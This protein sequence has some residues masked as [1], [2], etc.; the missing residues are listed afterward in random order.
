MLASA[1]KKAAEKLAKMVNPYAIK[2]KLDPV[3]I[4]PGVVTTSLAAYLQSPH[5]SAPRAA[6]QERLAADE[7]SVL[8]LARMLEELYHGKRLPRSPNLA[9]ISLRDAH[10][11]AGADAE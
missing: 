7:S 8:S 3:R 1:I 9:R 2:F 5:Y 6:L 10:K 11:L 4:R